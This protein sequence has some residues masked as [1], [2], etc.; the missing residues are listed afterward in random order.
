MARRVV[1]TTFARKSRKEI[2]L[3]WDNR[4]KSK[5]YSK[6]LNF[7]FQEALKIVAKFPQMSEASNNEDIRLKIVTHFELIY[8]VFED[9]ITVIDIWDTRQNP[10][11]FPIK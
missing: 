8:H 7:L 9:Q 4:N 1:W 5:T 2:F 11:N 3:Y 10:E 6:K